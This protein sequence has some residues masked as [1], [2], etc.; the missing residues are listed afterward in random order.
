MTIRGQNLLFLVPVFLVAGLLI[1]GLKWAADTNTL[2][3]GGKEQIRTFAVAL[4][5]FLEAR[6]RLSPNPGLGSIQPE[7]L[8]RDLN[9]VQQ[10]FD[11]REP[12]V[13][14][15]TISRF[16]WPEASSSAGA[17]GVV[18]LNP[19]TREPAFSYA[20]E[21]FKDIADQVKDLTREAGVM[22][23]ARKEGIYISDFD[24]SLN[25]PDNLW[26]LA[27]L[28]D[29]E[30]QEY[31]ILGVQYDGSWIQNEMRSS[32]VEIA[33]G[34]LVS[35]LAGIV[36]A[37]FLSS[38]LSR[39]LRNLAE[40]A[41]KA[42]DGDY[43]VKIRS[44]LIQEFNDLGNTFRTMTSLLYDTLD[45]IRKTLIE[46]EQFRNTDD[47]MATFRSSAYGTVAIQEDWMEAQM[48][49]LRAHIPGHFYHH[50]ARG[51]GHLFIMGWVHDSSEP[52]D[53]VASALCR[54]VDSQ[55]AREAQT[56]DLLKSA[57]QL[58]PA[59]KL[60]A[61]EIMP[62]PAHG[63][64]YLLDSE[65]SGAEALKEEFGSVPESGL[66]FHTLAH[67]F[68]Q[69]IETALRHM[70]RGSAASVH[71]QIR[72]IASSGEDGVVLYIRGHR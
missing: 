16:F 36:I 48:G 17:P 50:V 22:V 25:S 66:V 60:I 52:D 23:E 55:V 72:A 26:A 46:Q 18:I 35:A 30:G 41:S 71:E 34:V 2:R 21:G 9:R 39:T 3:S 40:A 65:H 68:G 13:T 42:A 20:P 43:D 47:L 64:S 12:E 51:H 58:F 70:E 69:R 37:L 1:G 45:R 62:N 10:L 24:V 19:E 32:V 28:K 49:P 67:A 5:E 31:A 44:G 38:I 15:S 14:T 33:I 27:I 29:Q 61:V 53:L 59:R 6:E 54:F 63:V 11:L 4:Q 56:E 8:K 7:I 57:F